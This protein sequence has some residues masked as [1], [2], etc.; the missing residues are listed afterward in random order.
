MVVKKG[1]WIAALLAFLLLTTGPTIRNRGARCQE[2]FGFFSMELG[3][4]VHPDR[5]SE[6]MSMLAEEGSFAARLET[7]TKESAAC[8]SV[9]S[10]NG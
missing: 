5:A 10:S 8:A 6:G 4:R 9:K 3:G 7:R 2:L 1:A